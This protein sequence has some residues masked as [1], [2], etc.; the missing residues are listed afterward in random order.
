LPGGP[1]LESR[2]EI[3]PTKLEPQ[4]KTN[5]YVHT[6]VNGA[7]TDYTFSYT[8]NPKAEAVTLAVDPPGT[9]CPTCKYTAEIS[10]QDPF[11][12][13]EPCGNV[14][15]GSCT[16]GVY[17]VTVGQAESCEPPAGVI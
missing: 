10:V 1:K 4:Q 15:Q 2:I 8:L 14:T 11:G 13:I 3:P 12:A 9:V 7:S 6:L 5:E 16:G 17:T